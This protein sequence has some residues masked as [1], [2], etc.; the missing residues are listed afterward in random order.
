MGTTPIGNGL[1]YIDHLYCGIEAVKQNDITR[2]TPK[3]PIIPLE[4]I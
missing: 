3:S 2:I 4:V 1:L